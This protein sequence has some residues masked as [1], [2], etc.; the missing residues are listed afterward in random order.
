MEINN[1][2][3]AVIQLSRI[4]A[5]GFASQYFEFQIDTQKLLFEKQHPNEE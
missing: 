3:G 1:N 2:N 4:Q 5:D